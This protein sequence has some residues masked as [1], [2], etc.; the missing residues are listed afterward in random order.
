M[1]IPRHNHEFLGSTKLAE[2]GEDRHNHRFAGVSGD[3]IARGDSHVHAIRVDTD[4]LD[5]RHQIRII[6]G[7]AI[8][9]GKGKHIH[10]VQGVTTR[11]DGHVHVFNLGTLIDRPL[12]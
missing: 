6:T 7:P 10:F 9:V 1:R 12:V 2:P 5:H 4:F 11:N 8:P 3:A